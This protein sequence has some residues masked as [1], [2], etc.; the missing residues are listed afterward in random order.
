MTEKP[1]PAQ[2]PLIQLTTLWFQVAG[3]QC[4][5]R[6]SHCF[7]SCGP[8]DSRLGMMTR[9][10]IQPHA[11]EARKLGVKEFY[12]T[13]GEPFLNSELPEILDD[14][15][16][17][18][19]VTVLSNGTLVTS[20]M[21]DRL[22]TVQ[23]QRPNTL[24]LRVSMESPDEA[25]NDMVRGEGSFRKAATGIKNLLNAG[26]N[27]IITATQNG[28]ADI[29]D[30][31]ARWAS[32][33][34][35]PE[36]RVKV[37]P[38]LYMGRAAESIRPY[39]DNERVTE[40]CFTNYNFPKGNLQCSWCRMVTSNGVHVCPILVDHPPARMGATLQE[41]LGAYTL[42]HPACYTCRVMGLCCSDT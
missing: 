33:L 30:D 9:A 25:A 2:I 24:T 21:A 10:E 42:D 8:D 34:G 7:I 20:A 28:N 3:T 14:L 22:R 32:L 4:N 36:P 41:S 23:K 40:G 31:M 19:N 27:P 29:A 35:A 18:G 37:M 6:C 15:L 11:E 16:K 5:L 26:F 17:A 13:G 1:V 12:L 38:A 39:R